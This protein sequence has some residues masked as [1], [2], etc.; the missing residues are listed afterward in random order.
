MTFYNPNIPQ[1]STVYSDWQSLLQNNFSALDSAYKINH[2]SLTASSKSG[3]HTIIELI[4]LDSDASQQT[5]LGEFAT[6]SKNVS[7]QTDQILMQYEGNGTEFQYTNYQIYD[8][9]Q[10]TNQTQ[11]FSSLPGKL[12]CYFGSVLNPVSPDGFTGNINLL[13]GICKNVVSIKYTFIGS[14]RPAFSTVVLVK[15]KDIITD[16]TVYMTD[17]KI[18]FVPFYYFV[19]ANI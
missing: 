9:L 15:S 12:I 14:A 18:K 2:V 8:L 19:L 4:Q 11:Y 7:G 6:F 13:P 3:N 1:T 5:N 17:T 10:Q 16:I